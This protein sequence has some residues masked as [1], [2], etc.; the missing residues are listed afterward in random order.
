[1]AVVYC[2]RDRGFK[3]DNHSIKNEDIV[4]FLNCTY[5]K[6]SKPSDTYNET[7]KKSLLSLIKAVMENELT[8]KQKQVVLLVKAQ[9]LK[10]KDVAQIMRVTNSTVC[11]HLKAAQKKF[12]I[13]L[14]Y[15]ECNKTQICD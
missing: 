5:F 3:Q 4:D 11:R 7:R 13:A 2:S 6:S 14:R 10:Q 12:D 9:G 1:M 15:F 8:D